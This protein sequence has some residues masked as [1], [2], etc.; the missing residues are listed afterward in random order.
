MKYLYFQVSS[1]RTPSGESE[2]SVSCQSIHQKPETNEENTRENKTTKRE[3][4]M[5][6]EILNFLDDANLQTS[7]SP[8]P[9][10]NSETES[11]AGGF[12]RPGC[13]S[14]SKLHGM[15]MAPLTEEVLSLQMLVQDKDNK[16]IVME[17]ALQH[18][19]ELLARNVKTAKRELN[20]RCKAQK[21]EYEATLNRHVQ[22]IQQLVEEKKSLAGKCETLATEM[23]QQAAKIEYERRIND[24]RHNNEIRRLKQV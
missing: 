14:V 7:N 8:I 19:R 24:E 11:N 15:S 16:L 5:L 13:E 18:Q 6:S 10:I 23:R 9:V 21:E 2:K 17:R 20:L 4:N 22:F 12:R 1:I 3:P